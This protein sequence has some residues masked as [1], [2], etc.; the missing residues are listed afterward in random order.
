MKVFYETKDGKVFYDENTAILHEAILDQKLFMI[1]WHGR[2]TNDPAS[3]TVVY[4]GREGLAKIFIDEL[5]ESNDP[6]GH[7]GIG[8][9]SVGLFVWDRYASKYIQIPYYTA[10]CLYPL[11]EML[12][13]SDDRMAEEG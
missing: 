11:L 3:A 13:N 9:G 8:E 2:I 6:L 12:E 4:I 7:E 5:R 10:R 1:D